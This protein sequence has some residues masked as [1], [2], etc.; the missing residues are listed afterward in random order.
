VLC[1]KPLGSDPSRVAT[2]VSLAEERGLIFAE[3]FM[4]R[5][6]PQTKLAGELVARGE[7]GK[8]R[9]INASMTFPIIDREGDDIRLSA[10]L[11][12]GSLM[13]VGCYCVSALRLFAGEPELVFADF[14]LDGAAV[15][16]RVNGLLRF[17]DGATGQFDAA[18]N[19]PRR[20]RLEL[21]GEDASIIL[22]DPWHCRLP[23]IEVRRPKSDTD[24]PPA[25][26]EGTEL[27]AIDPDG[28]LG[29]R[30]DLFDTY[31][32]EIEAFSAAVETGT[33]PEFAGADAVSQ[34]RVVEA[35]VESARSGQPVKLSAVEEGMK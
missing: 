35:I 4:Y 8:L 7:I 29:L 24:G 32:L 2:V 1:E 28:V 16:I 6:H 20:D 26:G 22:N 14:D 11:D 25:P 15:D 18:M 9:Q 10:E 23:S 5:Y 33:P 12:G 27:I 19:L 34:A 3:A 21:V 31:R 17:S 13:D 30:E